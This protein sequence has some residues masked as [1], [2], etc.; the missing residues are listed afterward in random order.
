M[1]KLVM[2]V[3]LP[4]SGKSEYASHLGYGYVICSSD[5]MRKKMFGDI[6]DQ[7]HNDEVFKAL[8]EEIRNFLRNGYNVIY[9]ACNIN[10]KRRQHFINSLDG[11]DCTKEAHI[12]ALPYDMVLEQNKNRDR[13]VPEYVIKRMYKSWQTP[14]KWE[15][16]DEIKL[17]QMMPT[18]EYDVSIYDNYDQ[19]N[20]Y[21][22]RTLGVHMKRVADYITEKYHDYIL[23]SAALRHDSGKPFCEF[24]DENGISH[25]YGHESVGAY[26]VLSEWE[27]DEDIALELSR[28]INY[29]MRPLSWKTEKAAEKYRKLWG[30]EFFNSIMRLHEA[31][32]A[33]R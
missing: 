28:L 16:F 13:V 5:E 29:H 33:E 1:S 4:G 2:M 25:Y 24:K 18:G 10:S 22:T 14:A 31:D 32:V 12:I 7:E 30:E 27:W 19:N 21:H 17:I 9:D 23:Y 6:N 3:G 15:G 8:H 11:I 26:D 20:P